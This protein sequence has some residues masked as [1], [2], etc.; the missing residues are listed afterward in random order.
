MKSIRFKIP[1]EPMSKQRHRTTKTGRTYTPE[2]TVNYENLIKYTYM[3]LENR[4]FWD[5]ETM[6]VTIIALF[7]IPK[8]FSKS[9]VKMCM[10]GAIA[11]STKDCDNIAKIVCD[12]LNNIA[13]TDDKH[14]CG[15]NVVKIYT[16]DNSKVGVYVE[17]QTYAQYETIPLNELLWAIERGEF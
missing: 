11:P 4:E 16:E 8:S 14:I 1:G 9:R 10:G 17:I 12:G 2:Q 5:N 6:Q 13:Y 7:S 15:L 3:S